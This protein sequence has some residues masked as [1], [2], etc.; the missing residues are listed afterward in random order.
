MGSIYKRGDTYWI[1]YCHKGKVVRESSG[2][3]KMEVAKRLL[4]RRE[5]KISE[6][7]QPGVHFEKV[8]VKELL[9]DFLTDY[10][11]NKRKSLRKAR[12][13]ADHL[14]EFFGGMKA[15]DVTTAMVKEYISRRMEEG[16]TNAT[17][18]RELSALKRSFNLA[19]QCTPPKV[20]E[21]PYIPT[22]RESNVRKG[23]FEYE[24]FVC[25]REALPYYARPVVT[26][27]YRTGWRK[28][29]VLDL[30]W[31][32][33]DL[34]EGTVRL[35]PG[36]SKNEE[37]RTLYLDSE[38]KAVL[39]EQMANR[40]LG[41]PY[42]FHRKGQKMADFRKAW[43]SACRKARLGERVFHDFRRT[44]VRNMVRAGIPERVAMMR[45][46]H[47][48][49]S[50][51]DRYNIVSPNDLKEAASKMESYFQEVM[52]TNLGTIEK[53]CRES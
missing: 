9:E 2:S 50:V 38:L 32:R 39:K 46:G 26:F 40:R 30:T 49:R 45:S 23:F 19:A 51:F 48:T 17:I 22:L 31:E 15:A 53:S 20:A 47:K 29:E 11:V 3:S 28:A 33:V 10:K 1:K 37:A 43:V 41:C 6:G 24:E 18:N 14:R 52:G 5:G 8:T 12:A 16:V 44:A 36:E 35:E 13:C 21:V 34:R 4:R 7:K 25:L 27:A 42:V